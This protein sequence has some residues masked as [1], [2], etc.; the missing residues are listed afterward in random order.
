MLETKLPD[1]MIP[2]SFVLLDALP[3][4][5]NGKVDRRALPDPD[6]AR[7]NIDRAYKTPAT[8]TEA[9]LTSIWSGVL[10]VDPVGVHD[11]FFDLGGH[12]LAASRVVSRVIQTFALELPVKALFDAPTVA[13]MAAIVEQNQAKRASDEN[14]AQMLRE[15]EAITEDEARKQLA[16][17]VLRRPTN[18]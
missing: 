10:S 5:P 7:P 11:N 17:E 1:Y 15:V 8:K 16:D 13:E 18:V 9:Q 6:N 12:S 3:I 2:S 14:L 4:K